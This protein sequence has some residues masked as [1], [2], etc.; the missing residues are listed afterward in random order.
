MTYNIAELETVPFET[1]LELCAYQ[2]Y[3]QSS[4]IVFIDRAAHLKGCQHSKYKP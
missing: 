2:P 1:F 4:M 3:Q